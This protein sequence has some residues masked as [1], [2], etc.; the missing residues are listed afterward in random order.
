MDPSSQLIELLQPQ[1]G[2]RI[3]DLGCGIGELSAR[4]AS[5]GA[6]I[7]GLDRLGFLL[8][9]ARFKFPGVEFVESDFFDYTP[10]A[11]FDAVFAHAVL[12]WIQPPDRALKRIFQFLKPGGR[13]AAALGGANET[14]RQLEAYYAPN[15]K[16]Y[17]KLLK[18]AGFA[19]ETCEMRGQDLFVL[20]RR[21]R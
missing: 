18:K 15:L 5:S 13:L 11:P 4:L 8:E 21:P 17:A 10:P 20:A 19:V 2:E 12:D 16:D 14:A 1:P 3:L 7:T 6:S 9:Q